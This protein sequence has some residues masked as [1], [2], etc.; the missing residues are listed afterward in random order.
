MLTA[1]TASNAHSYQGPISVSHTA[2]KPTVFGCCPPPTQLIAAT[3]ANI[4]AGLI[5]HDA[6]WHA[7]VAH[8]VPG[9]CSAG[10][11]SVS[12]AVE[13]H[14]S[15]QLGSIYGGLYFLL[16]VDMICVLVVLGEHGRFNRMRACS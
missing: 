6:L 13:R 10:L 3:A 11:W 9:C 4:T 7:G 8:A 14:Q 5:V 2:S 16:F 15:A 1:A 12:F